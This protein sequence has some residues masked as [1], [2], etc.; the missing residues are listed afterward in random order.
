M[1]NQENTPTMVLKINNNDTGSFPSDQVWISIISDTMN[2]YLDLLTGE[3]QPWAGYQSGVTSTKLSDIPN[4][5]INVPAI[6]GARVYFFIGEDAGPYM[7]ISGPSP[8]KPASTTAPPGGNLFFDMA[9]FDTHLAGWYNFDQS[10]VASYGISYT[11]TVIPQGGSQPVTHGISNKRSE[12]IGMFQSIPAS[13]GPDCGNSVIFKNLLVQNMAGDNILRAL[14]PSSAAFPDCSSNPHPSNNVDA[15]GMV[16]HFFDCYINE[17]CFKANRQFNFE[18]KDYSPLWGTV[19]AAG[20]T[21][22]LYTD[23]SHTTPYAPVPSLPRPDSTF[24][25]PMQLQ[26]PGF[27]WQKYSGANNLVDWGFVI[28]GAPQAAMTKGPDAAW[29]WVLQTSDPA[30]MAIAISICRQVMHYDDG[31]NWRDST[32]YYNKNATVPSTADLPTF[33]YAQILHSLGGN[34]YALSYDDVYGHSSDVKFDAG[35]TVTI[36][37]HSLETVAP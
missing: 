25:D 24:P 5:T 30:V 29:G 18:N 14:A 36:D 31:S 11:F 8:S 16:S 15:A 28:V 27:Y 13:G 22:Y 26:P 32:L 34:V 33:F 6:Q 37:L 20:D 19:N 7:A 4:G 23:E 12:V 35:A 21:M 17:L 3:L 9:E 1:S 10:N 2:Q